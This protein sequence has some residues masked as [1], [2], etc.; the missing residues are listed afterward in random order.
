MFKIQSR[1]LDG[2]QALQTTSWRQ[3]HGILKSL[4]EKEDAATEGC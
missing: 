1:C 3:N 4:D 2:A